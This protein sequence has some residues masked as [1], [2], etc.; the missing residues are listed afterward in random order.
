MKYKN[1]VMYEV[2]LQNKLKIILYKFIKD[3]KH[4]EE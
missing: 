1:V 4:H 3:R 2:E